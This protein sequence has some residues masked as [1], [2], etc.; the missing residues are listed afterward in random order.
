VTALPK[1]LKVN[2]VMRQII[3]MLV[4]MLPARPYPLDITTFTGTVEHAVRGL[5]VEMIGQSA[6][7]PAK[8]YIE[9]DGV[10]THF[11]PPEMHFSPAILITPWLALWRT[12]HYNPLRWETDPLLAEAAKQACQLDQIDLRVLTWKQNIETLHAALALIPRFMELRQ[13]YFPPA[14]AGLA[15]LWLLLHLTR[16]SSR[17][18]GLLAGAETKTTETNRRLEEL[19]AHIRRDPGLRKLFASCPAGEL[20]ATL[21][22]LPQ[23][24]DFLINFDAFLDQYGHREVSLTI[25]QGAWRDQPEIVLGILKVLAASEP[26]AAD[27][28]PA[29]MSERDAL[30]KHSILGIWP[31]RSPFLK[32]LAYARCLFQIREDTHF[33]A[34]LAQPPIR[35]IALELGRRLKQAGALD[36]VEDVFHL[37]LEELEALGEPWPPSS[38]ILARIRA[39]VSRRK[40][41]RETLAAT[42]LVDPRLLAVVPHAAPGEAVLLNGSPGSPGVASGPVR[43][44]LDSSQFTRLQP[45]D[46]LVAPATNPAWTPLFQ[47]AAA[48]VVDSGGAASHAAIVAR[49]YGVPAVMGTIDGTR[50]LKDGQRVRV[51]GSRG[52]VLIAEEPT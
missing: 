17:F 26:Q 10:I 12:H 41:R 39:L 33:Y 25:S 48:V 15:R 52:L 2:R 44:V 19:A 11:E 47:R 51:D 38:E 28:R 49:E 42:P 34:T 6:P 31:L 5:L 36:E 9:E 14:L 29:W 1:P 46:V 16:Q 32:A 43:I 18:G 21:A 45:G 24:T 13:R 20:R 40:A 30:L 23:G 50:L 35:H 27:S 4:E 8:L 37:R 22:D 3:P 7:D